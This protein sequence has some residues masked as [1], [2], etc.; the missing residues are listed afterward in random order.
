MPTFQEAFRISKYHDLF[1]LYKAGGYLVEGQFT[2][3]R[4]TQQGFAIIYNGEIITSGTRGD[5]GFLLRR[6]AARGKDA[7]KVLDNF[8]ETVGKV[9]YGLSR[10]CQE[11]IAFR[12]TLGAIARHDGNIAVFEWINKNGILERKAFTTLGKKDWKTLGYSCLG[13]NIKKSNMERKF[14]TCGLRPIIREIHSNFEEFFSFQW[15][16]G[17][18]KQD[19]KY[20]ENI[21]SDPEGDVEEIS[22]QAFNA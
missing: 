4:L 11:A 12:K 18:F 8:I 1:K 10:L 15:D 17:Y 16:T 6:I 13:T 21:Y 14:Y 5:V 22:E 2:V 3:K 7:V 20:M 19:M 9:E